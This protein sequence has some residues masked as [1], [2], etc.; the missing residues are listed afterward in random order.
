MEQGSKEP[1]KPPPVRQYTGASDSTTS[2][3]PRPVS[4]QAPQPVTQAELQQLEREVNTNPNNPKRMLL[5]AQKLVE[6]STVLASEYG[7]ADAK[8]TAKNS[9]RYINDAHKRIK[10]L[11]SAGYPQAQFYLADCYGTGSLGLQI[12]TKEAFGLYQAAAKQGHPEAAFRTAMC[13]ELGPNEGGGTK[14]DFEK[15]VQWYR[16]AATLGDPSGMYKL[17]VILLKPLLGQGRNV[18]EAVT[19]LKRAADAEPGNARAL[20]ELAVVHDTCNLDPEVRN[21]VVADDAY[22]LDLFKQSASLGHKTAQYRLGQAYE[23]GNLGLPID[24]RAS[25]SWYSKAAA[26]AEHQAE[27]ALSGWYLTGA[28]GILKQSDTEAYLWAR[29]AATSEPPLPKAMFA[30]GYYSEQ[31]IGCPASGEDARKW[32]GRAACKFSNFP[33]CASSSTAWCGGR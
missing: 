22:S 10:K 4:D 30:M 11:V 33:G 13:C 14:K 32:Y 16:R 18:A 31:G 23:Y 27:L 8:T 12:D 20:H 28:E 17:G 2:S 26:Q 29:R 21:K 24:Q 19:W 25:I 5:Y 6:A 1:A 3:K 7:R 9:E 15:A